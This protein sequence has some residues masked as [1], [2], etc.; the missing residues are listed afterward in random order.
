LGNVLIIS[1]EDKFVFHPYDGGADIILPSTETRDSLKR[2]HSGW[3]SM[4]PNGY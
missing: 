3:L 2:V 1:V 4:H